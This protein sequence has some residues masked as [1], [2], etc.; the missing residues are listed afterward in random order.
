MF[1]NRLL[2]VLAIKPFLFLWLA[3]IFSQVAINM[4]NFILIIVTFKISNSNAA[5]SGIIISYT[6][7]AILLG[8]LAGVYVDRWNKKKV[9]LITNI[10]RMLLLVVLAFAHSNLVVIYALALIISAITQFF[11]PAETP[12]IPLVVS[13][14]LLLTA[15]ALFGM[16]VYGSVLVA[17]ALSGPFIIFFGER[18]V[19]VILAVFFFL[20]T[21]FVSFLNVSKHGQKEEEKGELKAAH[22][23]MQTSL[24]DEI[25]EACALMLKTKAIYHSLILLV[26]SQ[27]VI[28]LL[29]VIGPGYAK[30]TLNIS[31]NEFPLLFVTPAALGMVV[32]AVI[33]G[34]FFHNY[35]KVKSATL[36]VFISGL[37]IFMLQ[38]GYKGTSSGLVGLVNTFLP[39]IIQLDMLHM[40]VLLGVILGFA[41][42]LVFV[43]SN[44]ILQEET[45]EE[46][47]GKVYGA[48]NALIGIFSL[49]PVIIVGEL[50]DVLGVNIVLRGMGI[51]I[52]VFGVWRFFSEIR[53][54]LWRRT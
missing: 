53:A 40:I 7:P 4:A 31:V 23:P 41:N 1:N 34:N 54:G 3:E 27:L 15:N 21:I 20:A 22:T 51:L 2:Q 50:A 49:L 44:T 30:E 17:Y 36:G 25:K 24:R 43:P 13:K 47:R 16:G 45:S 48:L 5:V 37:T 9:L 33:I 42:A 8:L 14:K 19:F 12:I 35:S 52:M 11:I 29:G 38:F 46:F 6:I 39:T 32:G 28:L 18:Y 10:L 26:L